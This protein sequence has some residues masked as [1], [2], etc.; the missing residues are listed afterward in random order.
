MAELPSDPLSEFE[1]SEED[2]GLSGA[3]YDHYP[4]DEVLTVR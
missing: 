3:T 2:Q 1:S 4:E